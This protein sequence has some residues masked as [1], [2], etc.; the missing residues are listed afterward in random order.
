VGKKPKRTGLYRNNAVKKSWRGSIGS[1]KLFH[2]GSGH[3]F[4]EKDDTPLSISDAIGSYL[5][6][7]RLSRNIELEEVSAATGISPGV[8]RS[9]ENDERGLLPAEVYVKAFYKKYAEYLGLDPEKILSAYNQHPRNPRKPGDRLNLN[10]VITL[11]GQEETLL[12]G[13]ARRLSVPVIIVLLGVLLYWLYR[14]Y[15]S[16]FKLP[17]F[18]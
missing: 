18:F 1:E 10:T 17:G 4:P 8:L 6:K 7:K 11:K 13:I 15:L 12:A 2:N 3:S 9:L 16:S 5:R 14:N